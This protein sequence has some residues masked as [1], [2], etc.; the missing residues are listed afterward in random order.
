MT[1]EMEGLGTK[2]VLTIEGPVDILVVDYV[3]LDGAETGASIIS[4]RF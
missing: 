4:Y 2:P 3:V 1:G